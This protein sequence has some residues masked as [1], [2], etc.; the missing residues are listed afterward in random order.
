MSYLKAFCK[1][2]LLVFILAFSLNACNS[3]RNAIQKSGLE[4][5]M[6]EV[7]RIGEQKKGLK[8]L[9][10]N[11]MIIS[12]NPEFIEKTDQDPKYLVI[13]THEFVPLSLRE[14]PMTEDQ[15]DGRKKLYLSLTEDASAKLADFS[16]KHIDDITAI[17]VNGEALTKHRIRVQLTS[18]QLQVT[19]CTDNAC[20][21]LYLHLQDNVK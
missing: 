14:K 11:E 3:Q 8:P 18:G 4:D 16:G 10:Q 1:P 6:Y 20:E 19:R 17:V 15:D 12:F 7:V 9:A 13:R 5:G 2:L 21:L